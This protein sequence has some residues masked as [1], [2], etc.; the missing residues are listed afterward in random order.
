MC[1]FSVFEVFDSIRPIKSINDAKYAHAL[2][3]HIPT[4]ACASIYFESAMSGHYNHL[5]GYFEDSYFF[6]LNSNEWA[7]T[8]NKNPNEIA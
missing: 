6:F 4:H 3:I 8:F 7:V 2:N 1:V 5:D